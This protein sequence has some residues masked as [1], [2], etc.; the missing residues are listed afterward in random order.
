MQINKKGLMFE[1]LLIIFA[2][3][4]LS[5][6][7][8]NSVANKTIEKTLGDSSYN[9]LELDK[10][11]KLMLELA[12]KKASYII[13]ESIV[14]LG[15][16][17]GFN[18]EQLNE[19]CY[20][21]NDYKIKEKC[22]LNKEIIK[23]NL[24]IY[25]QNSFNEYAKSQDLGLY[26]VDIKE[27]NNKLLIAFNS[28]NINLKKENVEFGINNKFTKEINYNLNIY[29]ELYNKFHNLI[30]EKCP[31]KEIS[32]DEE[33]IINRLTCNDEDKKEAFFTYSNEK[34][35]FQSEKSFLYPKQPVIKFRVPKP[36]IE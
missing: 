2:V 24:K 28:P 33:L 5:T 23:E 31:D 11:S 16:N 8:Y 21:W 36:Q 14:K 15:E 20:F 1:P 30:L 9:I 12:E 13:Y 25:I 27:E 4:I 18:T 3:I 29:S 7:L 10:E 19:K 17:S 6:A 26:S 35:Y 22:R 32:T 34:F